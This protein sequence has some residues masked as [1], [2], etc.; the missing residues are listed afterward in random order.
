MKNEYLIENCYDERIYYV[1]ETECGKVQAVYVA[2]SKDLPEDCLIVTR[3][4]DTDII[5]N[6][7]KAERCEKLKPYQISRSFE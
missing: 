3:V 1:Q 7:E 5:I 2:K 4:E 6:Q